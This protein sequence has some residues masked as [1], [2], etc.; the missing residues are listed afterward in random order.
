MAL[1]KAAAHYRGKYAG[2]SRAVRNG[3]RSADD[4][5]FQE[6]R[7]NL[8][9]QRAEDRAA[10]LVAEIVAAAPAFTDEQR[11]TIS[12]LLRTGGAA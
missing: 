5:E 10:E 3:E 6:V 12:A 2:L 1:S 9:K 7:R 11:A 4:P 8:E